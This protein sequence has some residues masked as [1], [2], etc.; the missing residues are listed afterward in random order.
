MYSLPLLCCFMY[1]SMYLTLSSLHNCYS[2]SGWRRKHITITTPPPSWAFPTGNTSTLL[3]SC[4]SPV[5]C[6]RSLSFSHSFLFPLVIPSDIVHS[7][8]LSR[9]YRHDHRSHSFICTF[10]LILKLLSSSLLFLLVVPYAVHLLRMALRSRRHCHGSSRTTIS[11][12]FLLLL[13]FLL[14]C[15]C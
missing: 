2:T 14:W 3:Y 9:L 12:M 7:E 13:A 8:W 11:C 1:W 10:S 4:R 15:W 5:R 6:S